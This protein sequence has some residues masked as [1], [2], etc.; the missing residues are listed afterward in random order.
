MNAAAIVAYTL[1]G[2]TAAR[3]ARRRPEVP[4]LALTPDLETSRRLCL[5]WGAHSVQAAEVTTYEEMVA[6]AIDQAVK[7]GFAKPTD[8]VV[9]T[10]GIPFAVA[11]TTNNVRIAHVPPA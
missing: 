1:S 5:L 8:L 4:I 10:A 2:T 9:I 6:G 7:E 3:I 11:G